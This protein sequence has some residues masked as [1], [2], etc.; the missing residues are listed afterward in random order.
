VLKK[1]QKRLQKIIII[2]KE[3]IFKYFKGKFLF[4]IIM[5]IVLYLQQQQQQ[6]FD[7]RHYLYGIYLIYFKH[8]LKLL[9]FNLNNEFFLNVLIHKS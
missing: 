7:S 8:H 4:K 5:L 3:K 9:F 2:I 1:Q 6:R